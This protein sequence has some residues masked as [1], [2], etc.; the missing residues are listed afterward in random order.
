MSLISWHIFCRMKLQQC[1]TRYIISI[2]LILKECDI[3]NRAEWKL[4]IVEQLVPP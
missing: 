2:S 1:Y 4:K 3:S